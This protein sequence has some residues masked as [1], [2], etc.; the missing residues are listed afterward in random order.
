MFPRFGSIH[1]VLEDVQ[2]CNFQSFIL[3]E[4]NLKND[5][6]NSS[7]GTTAIESREK[8]A[9]WKN[10]EK[11]QRTVVVNCLEREQ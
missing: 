5:Y 9:N 3:K 4:I 1:K 2:S 7:C 11:Y 6:I 10:I 8:I